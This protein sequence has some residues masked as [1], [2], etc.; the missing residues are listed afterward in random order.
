M[1]FLKRLFEQYFHFPA[2]NVLPLQGQLG[3]SGRVIVRLTGGGFSAIGIQYPVR[4]ENVAFLEFSR[5]FRRHGLPVPEIYAEDL[6]QGAYL[7]EDLGD[8]TLFEFLSSHRTGE[9]I[10]PE[11]VDV[12]RKV[13]AVLPRFQVEAG[14]D[15]NYKVCYPR[16]S[17][18]RQSIAWDLNYFKYY[19]LRLA[20]IPFNEQALEHDFGRL[21]K[22]LLAAPHDYFLYRDFQSRNVMLRDGQ[23]FFLDYQGG[24]KGALQYDIASLLYDGKA[25]L[26]PELRQELLDYYMDCLTGFITVDRGAFM[27]HYYAFVYVRIMQALGAYG[28]RG[29]YERKAHF[30]QSVPYAMK[31]LRWLAHNVKLPIALPSL[32]E[33]FQGMLGSEKLQSLAS[34]ADVL[35]VRIFSFSFHRVM[36]SDESGNG[37]GF[38]FDARSLPNPGREERFKQLTGKDA[39]VIDYLNEQQSVHQFFASILSLVESTVSEYQRRGFKNLMVSFGCTGGQHR[40]VYLAERLAKHMRGANGVDVAVRHI[41]LEN[42]GR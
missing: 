41:E 6:S 23:P 3:G 29:F 22:F 34:S 27:E 30:L 2:D 32:L 38:V 15:L 19:F 21:T 14:R 37:G 4:E 36:P 12:Y 33:A 24:R 16:S 35:T 8:T 7:E 10:A 25:D 26:P 20:G 40:S 13:V 42:M 1:E 39:P 31:N 18:D 17:F 11:A 28:F 9:S 5:H